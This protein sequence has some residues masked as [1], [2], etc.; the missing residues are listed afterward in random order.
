MHRITFFSFAGFY[1]AQMSSVWERFPSKI[2]LLPKYCYRKTVVSFRTN[3]HNNWHLPWSLIFCL[4]LHCDS[5]LAVRHGHTLCGDHL[6][7]CAPCPHSATEAQ[8]YR[9]GPHSTNSLCWVKCKFS[10]VFVQTS[11]CLT[12]PDELATVSRIWTHYSYGD[13]T[14]QVFHTR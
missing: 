14:N 12:L 7:L 1:P 3:K 5:I 4:M 9:A 11:N 10:Q 13:R 2:K 6:A 8:S